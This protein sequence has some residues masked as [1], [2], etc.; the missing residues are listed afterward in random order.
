MG[1]FRRDALDEHLNGERRQAEEFRE[2]MDQELADI[3]R[4]ASDRH[5]RAI[6][7]YSRRLGEEKKR[8]E[9]C[10]RDIEEY[11]RKLAEENEKREGCERV[12]ALLEERADL[13]TSLLDKHKEHVRIL[14]AREKTFKALLGKWGRLADGTPISDMPGEQWEQMWQAESEATELAIAAEAENRRR[15]AEKRKLLG[16]DAELDESETA[17]PED[18][19]PGGA[20]R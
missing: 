18:M 15:L 12:I 14:E 1:L 8:R 17:A 4:R 10:E 2:R 3:N 6:A 13:L 19:K 16:P 5:S 9:S 20:A 7:D 11:S